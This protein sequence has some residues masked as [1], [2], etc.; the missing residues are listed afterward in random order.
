MTMGRRFLVLIPAVL[1]CGSA[2][3]AEKDDLKSGPQ[4]GDNLPGPFHSLVAHSEEPRWVGLK[5]DFFEA[6]GA[7]P[8]VLVFAREMTKPLTRMVKEL[9]AEVAKGKSAKLKAVVVILSDDDALEKN[10]KEFGEKQGIK[11]VN[12]AIMEPDGP[13]HYK[14]SK[15]ADVTVIAYKNRKVQ[16]NHAFKKGELNEEGVEKILADVR[17]IASKQ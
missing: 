15:E 5:M 14:V 7:N 10:L 6:Y 2:V 16:A 1:L 12:L 8:V 13:K 3:P 4:A 11:H 9:E 17:K